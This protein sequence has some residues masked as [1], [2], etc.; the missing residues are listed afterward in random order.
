MRPSP[1]LVATA[2]AVGACSP[3]TDFDGRAAL[4][5]AEI[6]ADMKR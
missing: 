3:V 2:L 6:L 5:D 4:S 1:A